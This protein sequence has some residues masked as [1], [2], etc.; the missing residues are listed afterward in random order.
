[1]SLRLATAAMLALA[2]A[3]AGPALACKGST[4]IL[5]DNF[6]TADANWHG[7]VSIA[8][9]HAAVT[10]TPFY[11]GQN[12]VTTTFGGAFYGGKH[13][14]SGDMCVDM[15][16]PQVSDP[17]TASA[18]IVFGFL[19]SLSFWVFFAR[20]DG[21][22]AVFHLLPFEDSGGA[23]AVLTPIA[24]QPSAVLKSGA[25]VTNTLRVTW[26][27]KT[28]ATYINDQPFWPFAI[29]QPFQNT[30]V[31]LYVAPAFPGTYSAQESVPVTYQFSNLKIT[32][33]P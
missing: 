21:Q 14:D 30:F 16:G 9:G 13:I 29:P 27:G 26:S 20:E 33:V 25:G 28:G 19:D 22:A 24:Y 6:Q 12:F 32:S 18:G 17:T 1:V 3:F 5:Q 4:T 23:H 2:A 31:G 7:T 8:G 11:D 10:S 15:V